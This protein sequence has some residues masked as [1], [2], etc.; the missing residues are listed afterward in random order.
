[1]VEHGYYCSILAL[2]MELRSVLLRRCGES[3]KD[4]GLIFKDS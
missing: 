4:L 1:M 2:E 3:M